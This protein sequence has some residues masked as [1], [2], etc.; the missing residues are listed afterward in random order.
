MLFLDLFLL[1]I[2]LGSWALEGL[3]GKRFFED[4]LLILDIDSTYVIFFD[5]DLLLFFPELF[6]ELL[7]GFF[8]LS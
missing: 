3:G 1:L 5:D 4:Y 6:P 2:M 7:G 8:T